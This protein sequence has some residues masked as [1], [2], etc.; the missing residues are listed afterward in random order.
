MSENQKDQITNVDGLVPVTRQALAIPP[1]E[2][3]N[4]KQMMLS[5]EQLVV[6][7]SDQIIQ[8]LPTMSDLDIRAVMM[9]ISRLTKK[10]WY[11]RALCVAELLRR[12]QPQMGGRSRLAPKNEGYTAFYKY[13]SEKLGFKETKLR[14]DVR[15]VEMFSTHV[16]IDSETGQIKSL[17]D[18][19]EQQRRSLVLSDD[20]Q[21][22]QGGQPS[23]I[24]Q[25]LTPSQDGEY[26]EDIAF[27][28]EGKITYAAHFVPHEDLNREHYAVLTRL[29]DRDKARAKLKEVVHRVEF[30]REVLSAIALKDELF[31]NSDKHGGFFKIR[32]DMAYNYAKIEFTLKDDDFE[33]FKKVVELALDLEGFKLKQNLDAQGILSESGDGYKVMMKALGLYLALLKSK[34]EKWAIPRTFD[35]KEYTEEKMREK[36]ELASTAFK[37]ANR[38]QLDK[39]RLEKIEADLEKRYPK[40]KRD[41]EVWEAYR[42][43]EIKVARALDAAREAGKAYKEAEKKG[44]LGNT[45]NETTAIDKPATPA[46]LPAAPTKAVKRRPASQPA[47]S[48]TSRLAAA[49]ANSPETQF[50]AENLHLP[51]LPSKPD[52]ADPDKDL[53]PN[54]VE[55]VKPAKTDK[56]T[57]SKQAGTAAK[58]KTDKKSKSK[59]DL[60][61]D[62]PHAAFG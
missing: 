21:K 9:S 1:V 39:K 61:E 34:R 27:S 38:Y 53:L 47:P 52:K 5:S 36:Q 30:D 11:L 23:G 56:K 32:Q 2:D 43:Q 35:P 33:I 28:I 37:K 42:G 50:F 10:M 51:A 45:D 13:W 54:K 40:M 17:E 58:V 59:K 55:D 46:A 14:E 18:E 49:W 25:I 22:R 8:A 41:G 16:A 20:E 24:K 44:R 6:D 31:K 4:F 62:D 26:I 48:G 15:I 3:E 29:G 7:A 57:A 19:E 12:E 60:E